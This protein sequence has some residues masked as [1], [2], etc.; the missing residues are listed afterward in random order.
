MKILIVEDNVTFRE[1]FK[2]SLQSAYPNGTDIQEVEDGSKCMEKVES[3]R[4]ELIFMDIR[5]PGENGLS[6]TKKIK[7]KY[8]GMSVIVLTSYDIPEFR[9][10]A[11]A[12]GADQFYS[13]DSLGLAE[14]KSLVESI[15]SV[16]DNA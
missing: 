10:S 15:S 12:S 3:F 7:V 2:Q 11:T 6:L 4:P 9:E 1:A 13:K 8:P 16:S 14:L 5:L